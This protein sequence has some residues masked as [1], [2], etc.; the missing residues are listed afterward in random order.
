MPSRVLGEIFSFEIFNPRTELKPLLRVSTPVWSVDHSLPMP[1]HHH[2]YGVVKI[3]FSSA[4]FSMQRH[5][6]KRTSRVSDAISTQG[7]LL[8]GLMAHEMPIQ[9]SSAPS[10]TLM[11]SSPTSLLR[12]PRWISLEM[13]LILMKLLL[14]R[15]LKS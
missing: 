2:C 7:L 8:R 11:V 5:R 12:G 9:M 1:T 14:R 3:I 4:I 15:S 6:P 13:K 10:T